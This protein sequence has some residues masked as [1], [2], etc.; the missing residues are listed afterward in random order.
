MRA[1]PPLLSVVQARRLIEDDSQAFLACVIIKLDT[2]T[3]LQEIPKVREHP[4]VFPEDLPGLPLEHEIEF[5]IKLLLG[6]AQVHK[7][8]YRMASGK[9]RE[10]KLQF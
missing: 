8:P 6:I 1:L 10:L 4:D 2:E 7:A 9:M 5:C 3:K